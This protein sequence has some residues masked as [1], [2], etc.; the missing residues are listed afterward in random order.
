MAYDEVSFTRILLA[1]STMWSS[2]LRFF[3]R[4]DLSIR[5]E[6]DSA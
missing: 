1:F 6:K 5:A 3:G 4:F 2:F